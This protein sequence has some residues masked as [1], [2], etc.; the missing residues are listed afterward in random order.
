MSTPTLELDRRPVRIGVTCGTQLQT[1]PF[2][3][4]PT[5]SLNMRYVRA[6]AR[7]GGLP[8][9]LVPS[10]ADPVELIAALDGLVLTGGGDLDPAI[11]GEE[12][13][14]QVYG[15]DRERDDFEFALLAAAEAQGV[16]VLAICRGLQLVNVS[17]A[18]T[19]IQHVDDHELHWQ[20]TP[21]HEGAHTV[22]IDPASALAAMVGPEDLL[23][24][25]YHHQAIDTLGDGLRVVA[26]AGGL[27]E[28]FETADGLITGI[29]WHPEQMVE[30]HPR[31]FALFEAFVRFAQQRD[32]Q[33]PTSDPTSWSN[34][35]V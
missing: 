8:L 12:A 35:H 1:T 7:A 15:V 17:R 16:P 28:A 34:S 3:E 10:G 32:R 6:V 27:P 23:V 22:A 4:Q 20:T 31:Q 14:D 25:S 11:Y 30:H 13:V 19:L 2:G 21:S 24:N 18:G 5:V 9:P 33:S 29:Q 26:D